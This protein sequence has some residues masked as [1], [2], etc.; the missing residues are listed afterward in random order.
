MYQAGHVGFV[1]GQ[2]ND[3]EALRKGTSQIEKDKVRNKNMDVTTEV[4]R[5]LNGPLKM[6]QMH[7]NRKGTRC[8]GI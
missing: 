2:Q 3:L 7:G 1:S 8:M 4:E 5:A 6:P